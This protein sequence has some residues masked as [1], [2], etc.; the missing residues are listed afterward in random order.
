MARNKRITKKPVAKTRSGRVCKKP[1]EIY[2]QNCVMKATVMENARRKRRA[3][4]QNKKLLDTFKEKIKKKKF[5]MKMKNGKK[6][7]D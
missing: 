2:Q 3:R 7:G 4:V 6:S 1:M 5:K